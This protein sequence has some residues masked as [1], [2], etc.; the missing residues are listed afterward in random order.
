MNLLTF[1][2]PGNHKSYFVPQS[3]VGKLIL[4]LFG[5]HI[6]LGDETTLQGLTFGAQVK[7]YVLS[8]VHL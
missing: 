3:V 2:L 5:T 8:V 1:S 4:K 6:E 7:A